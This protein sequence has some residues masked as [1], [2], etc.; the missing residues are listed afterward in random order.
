MPQ[1]E[2][3]HDGFTFNDC[4]LLH[5]LLVTGHVEEV[6]RRKQELSPSLLSHTCQYDS[7]GYTL[8]KVRL[9]VKL[10]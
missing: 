6:V 10:I 7:I 2:F 1:P 9:G 8:K 5:R 4:Q 3:E